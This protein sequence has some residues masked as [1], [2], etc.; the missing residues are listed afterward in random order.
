MGCGVSCKHG[1]DPLLLWLW[2]RLTTVAPIRPLAWKLPYAMGSALK[3]IKKKGKRKEISEFTKVVSI[4]F[5]TQK[6]NCT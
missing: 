1:L 4:N 2:H 3:S 6:L 5:N